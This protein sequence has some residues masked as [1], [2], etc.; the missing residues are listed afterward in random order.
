MKIGVIR[1]GRVGLTLGRRWSAA[2]H[3]VRYGVRNVE[4][5]NARSIRGDNLT[6]TAFPK[7]HTDLKLYYYLYH[8]AP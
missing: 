6:V 7:M 3:E 2:G 8:Q 4:S 1:A 5:P